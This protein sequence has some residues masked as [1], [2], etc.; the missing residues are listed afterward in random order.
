MARR[1]ILLIPTALCVLVCF[2]TPRLY[3]TWIVPAR[4]VKAEAAHWTN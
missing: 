4:I 3:A 1:T 2:G